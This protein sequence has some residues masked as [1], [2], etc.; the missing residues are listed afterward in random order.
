MLKFKS[1]KQFNRLSADKQKKEI[2]RLSE[3]VARRQYNM[4]KKLGKTTYESIY[5]ERQTKKQLLSSLSSSGSL[6]TYNELLKQSGDYSAKSYSTLKK[7]AESKFPRAFKRNEAEAMGLYRREK[8]ALEKISTTT[9]KLSPL[10]TKVKKA[11]ASE[12]ERADMSD[13]VVTY[14]EVTGGTVRDPSSISS[15]FHS[16]PTLEEARTWLIEELA[17][18]L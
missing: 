16:F 12:K 6:A 17:S 15:I 4:E 5:G 10:G 14:E 11:L 18:E 1:L 9:K 7:L 2:D 8:A 13:I 3:T